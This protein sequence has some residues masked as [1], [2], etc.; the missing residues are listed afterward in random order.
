MW[1]FISIL[2]ELISLVQSGVGVLYGHYNGNVAWYRVGERS[3]MATIM[4]MLPGTEW[5]A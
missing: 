5:G 4:A 1:G 2:T 3:Y